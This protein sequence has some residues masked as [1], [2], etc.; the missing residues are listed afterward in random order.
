VVDYHIGWQRAHQIQNAEIIVNTGPGATTADHRAAAVTALG[1]RDYEGA[2]RSFQQVLQSQPDDATIHYYLVLTELRGLHPDR[3][4]T[5]RTDAFLRRLVTAAQADPTCH[6]AKVLAL[7]INESLL[8]RVQRQQ[9]LAPESRR[10]AALVNPVHGREILTHV[11]VP[12]SPVWNCL[13][14][15]LGPAENKGANR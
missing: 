4:P 12:Q 2:A 11:P 10:L 15:R 14:R 9:Q 7:V 13:N 5:R 6:H 3:Y 8:A 1:Y